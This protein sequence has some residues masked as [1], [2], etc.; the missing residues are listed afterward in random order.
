L[1]ILRV[2]TREMPLADD[3]E[4]DAIAAAT[5]DATGAELQALLR[6]AALAAVDTLVD[7]H[8]MTGAIDRRTQ[9][10]ITQ[11]QLLAAGRSGR[12]EEG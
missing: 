6:R 9:L 11:E 3:V 7:A 8:G 1:E 4:L 2:L 5:P 12:I 10:E